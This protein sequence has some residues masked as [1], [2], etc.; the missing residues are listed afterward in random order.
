MLYPH[1]VGL[2]FCR[3]LEQ[4]LDAFEHG[5]LCQDCT[6]HCQ[7]LHSLLSALSVLYLLHRLMSVNW[8]RLWLPTQ[9]SGYVSTN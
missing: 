1:C 4:R 7:S 6:A 9:S 8:L 3:S 5:A 2:R